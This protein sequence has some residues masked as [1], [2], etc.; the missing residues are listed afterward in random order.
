MPKRSSGPLQLGQWERQSHP[1]AVL[2]Q[3]RSAFT[4]EPSSV[5][6]RACSAHTCVLSH[7]FKSPGLYVGEQHSIG[8]VAFNA[9]ERTAA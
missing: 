2:P 5:S 9:V 4:G 8:G 1:L 7:T 3:A 6:A